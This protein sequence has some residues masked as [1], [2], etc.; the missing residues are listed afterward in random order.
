MYLVTAALTGLLVGTPA[1]FCGEQNQQEQQNKQGS[2]AE[3]SPASSNTFDV[4]SFLKK[5]D[6]NNDGKIDRNELPADKRGA[7]DR[8]DRNKDG[9]LDRDEL[10]AHSRRMRQGGRPAEVV[11][12]WV[13]EAEENAPTLQELQE[14][15]DFLRKLD[16]DH[17]GKI[18]RDDITAA[19]NKLI[20]E[21]TD[22]IINEL[23]TNKDGKISRSE[24]EGT[25]LEECFDRVNQN[26][27]DGLTRQEIRRAL[28]G[29]SSSQASKSSQNNK[30]QK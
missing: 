26:R 9:K 18:T 23:D 13:I 21:R 6:K 27:D 19:R 29:L 17:N 30:T 4:D 22:A 10:Q 12:F 8:I 28:D 11:H 20:D 25:F 14:A 5:Y 15:Y 3:K 2:S 1:A 16:R 24:A 7:F